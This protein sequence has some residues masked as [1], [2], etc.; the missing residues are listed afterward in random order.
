[1]ATLPTVPSFATNDSSLS[2]LQALAYA[3]S[4]LSD[5]TYSPSWH[6]Y[7]GSTHTVAANTIIT[8]SF[9]LVAYDNDGLNDGTGVVIQ[10]QGYYAVEFALDFTV[11][12]NTQRTMGW[13]QHTAGAN[14]PNFTNGTT[15]IFG[16]SGL[17]SANVFTNEDLAICGSDVCPYVLYPGDMI[18]VQYNSDTACTRQTNLNTGYMGARWVPNFTGTFLRPGP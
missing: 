12:A 7:T 3:V 1:M 14:N 9:P 18:R 5:M 15:R 10:T 13:F 16:G 8:E 17:T 6:L 4:F 11:G 2:N